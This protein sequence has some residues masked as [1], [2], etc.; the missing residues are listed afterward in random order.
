LQAPT[1]RQLTAAV[2]VA[3]VVAGGLL[4]LSGANWDSG[5][6]L[7]P[8]E[9][10]LSQVADSIRWPGSAGEYLDVQSSPLSPYNT[11][12]GRSYLYGT[13]PLFSTKLVATVL[14]KDDYA[15]LDIVGRRLSALLD[16][17]SILLVFL[18]GRLLLQDLGRRAATAGA[19]VAAAL[20]AF[21]VTVVQAAHFFTMEGWLVFFTLLTFYFAARSLRSRPSYALTG[22]SL[23]LT[24]ACK[25]SGA[26]VALPVLIGLVGEAVVVA[27]R[28][29]PRDALLRFS[30]SVLTVVVAGY[31]AFRA[32]SPYA[33]A[34]SNWFDVSINASFRNALQSQQDAINGKFLY[35]P[36]YQWLLSPRLWD[37]LKNLVVWQLGVP[38]GVAALAGVAVAGVR[39]ARRPRGE[40]AFVAL[41]LRLMLLSFVLA[42]FFYFGSKF[43]HTGRYLLPL[44]PF[45]VLAAAYGVVSLLRGRAVVL[46][47]AGSA[48]V[49]MTGLYALAYRHVYTTPN[50]RVAAS[51]W[52]TQHI[53]AGTRIAIEHWD[54]SLP[55]GAAAQRYK[56]EVLPVFDPDDA[57][58]LRKLYDGLSTSK[59]YVLSSPRAWRTIG[60]LPDR[61]PI[62]SRF[63]PRLF[64]GSLGF[65]RVARFTSEPQL[66][67][68][69]LHDLGAEE[70]F[71][72]YDHPPVM[73]YRKRET[74]GWA[75]FRRRLCEPAP[76]P[77]GCG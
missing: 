24:A 26:L 34:D 32:V 25:V 12:T 58:K 53:P 6:H 16:T 48:L 39:S 10:Y 63:Y 46:A 29:R 65:A 36:S 19:L 67:G 72:V 61:F 30:A 28:T 71:W 49:V 33:F 55:V 51:E 17:A 75:G 3:I 22:A 56:G 18:L 68:V 43:A 9:R 4:R 35:P 1:E 40:E 38:L 66:F 41:T 44:V 42:V 15:H 8:D 27:R 37:P 5:Q 2:L 64:A 13:F 7:H 20:Y 59:Y 70:A 54:D 31:V 52:I 76:T 69:R 50:T 11:E 62:M 21:T 57:T 45:A 23:G 74:L 73:V 14:G 60:R 47:C 77:P